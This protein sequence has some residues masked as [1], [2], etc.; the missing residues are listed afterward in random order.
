MIIKNNCSMWNISNTWV[1]HTSK[2]ESRIAMAKAVFY[3]EKN[4]LNSKIYK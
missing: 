1:V 2:L 4:I 3:K